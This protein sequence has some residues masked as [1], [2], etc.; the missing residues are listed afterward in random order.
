MSAVLLSE[1]M[2]ERSSFSV[3]V[4]STG[5]FST[6]SKLSSKILICITVFFRATATSE[7]LHSIAVYV[8]CATKSIGRQAC[9]TTMSCSN[10]VVFWQ[11]TR[12]HTRFTARV[13]M[14]SGGQRYFSGELMKM[15]GGTFE[16]T[17]FSDVSTLNYQAIRKQH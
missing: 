5:V 11:A 16:Y 12:R 17:I 3:F 9:S 8:S 1:A 15:T 6:V 14:V 10:L 4:S 7:R 13:S 2:R